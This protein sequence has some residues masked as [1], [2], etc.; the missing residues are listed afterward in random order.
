MIEFDNHTFF[1]AHGEEA[2]VAFQNQKGRDRS[3][4]RIIKKG[5]DFG[6]Y[7]MR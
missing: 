5:R 1:P 2:F 6:G 7:S 4:A 3:N